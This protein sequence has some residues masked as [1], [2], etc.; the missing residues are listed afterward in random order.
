MTTRETVGMMLLRDADGK[1]HAIGSTAAFDPPM[2]NTACDQTIT[3]EL[4]AGRQS[5]ITCGDCVADVARW[6]DVRP[7]GTFDWAEFAS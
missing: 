6:D 5:E 2:A 7:V 3:A 4:I 1:V